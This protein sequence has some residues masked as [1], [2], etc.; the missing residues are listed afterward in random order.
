[1]NFRKAPQAM[2]L[3]YTLILSITY[4]NSKAFLC[5]IIINTPE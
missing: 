2:D 3:Y 5:Q 1:M 4:I